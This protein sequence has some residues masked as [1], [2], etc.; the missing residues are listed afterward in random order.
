MTPATYRRRGKGMNI[1][2]TIVDCHLGR[3]LV[4]GTERGVCA[5]QF[6]AQDEELKT[7]LAAEYPAANISS[8]ESGLSEWVEGLLRHLEGSQPALALPLDL[9]ATAFQTRVWAEL[10][11]IPYGATRSYAKVAEAI[12]QPTATRAVARACATN[13][14]ALITPCHRVV[15]E[16]GQL[17]G[18]RWGIER[19]E[20][21]LE[22][23]GD[24]AAEKVTAKDA[25][26]PLFS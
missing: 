26:R 10:R 2:Y 3:L 21:L 7:A 1:N 13:P 8:D 23:E 12:G 24:N 4:A 19:K 25:R 6:G 9:Q 5:V 15:R 11:Q 17:G 22:M 14:V 16:S 18:Y 20:R